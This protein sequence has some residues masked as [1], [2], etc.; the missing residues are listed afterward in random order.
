MKFSIKDYFSKCDQIHNFLRLSSQLLKKSLMEKFSFCAVELLRMGGE[1]ND[2]IWEK[3]TNV[4]LDIQKTFKG[5][6]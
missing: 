5:K 3:Y 2:L 1:W 6:S 4:V